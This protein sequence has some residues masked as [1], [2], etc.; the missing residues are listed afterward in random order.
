MAEM[1]PMERAMVLLLVHTGIRAAECAKVRIPHVGLEKRKLWIPKAKW[2]NDWVLF[3]DPLGV[4]ILKN[5]STSET[6]HLISLTH[7]GW[8]VSFAGGKD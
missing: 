6:E 2:N 3:L 8:R 4:E 7:P 5:I 1:D